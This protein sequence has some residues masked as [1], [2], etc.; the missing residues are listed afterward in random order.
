MQSQHWGG[1]VSEEPQISL[2]SQRGLCGKLQAPVRVPWVSRDHH[3]PVSS[4]SQGTSTR[5]RDEAQVLFA[6]LLD[7]HGNHYLGWKKV[8]QT[9]KAK[10][11][12][13]VSKTQDTTAKTKTPTA[14]VVQLLR[15]RRGTPERGTA[16]AKR[17]VILERKLPATTSQVLC[18]FLSV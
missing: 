3:C 5:Q 15:Y 13:T 10:Q 9:I 6:Y 14:S 2:T 16:C 11:A 7:S 12:P 4:V 18:S 17:K 1:Q 8:P